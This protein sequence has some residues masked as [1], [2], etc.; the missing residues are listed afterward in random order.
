MAERDMDNPTPEDDPNDF[1]QPKLDHSK[2]ETQLRSAAAYVQT[3]EFL[4]TKIMSKACEWE[5]DRAV[6]RQWA[7]MALT[8]ACGMITVLLVMR[9]LE[10]RWEF[11]NRSTSSDRVQAKADQIAT[12]HRLTWDASLAEA[13]WKQ[14]AEL[15]SRWTLHRSLAGDE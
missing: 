1:F 7:R 15:A 10:S 11:L 5:R 12:R 4:R 9:Q 2:L 3:T 13:F 8:L 14:R 6:D